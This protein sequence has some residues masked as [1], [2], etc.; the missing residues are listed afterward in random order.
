MLIPLLTTQAD[1]TGEYLT[2]LWVALGL[3]TVFC[4]LIWLGWRNRKRRQATL[5]APQEI[6]AH[7]LEREPLAAAEGMVIGTVSAADYL[8]RIAVH[9]LGL[10]TGGR[11]EHHT[12][13]VAVFRAGAR[14]YFIPAPSITS[15]RTDR[16]V[17]GKFVE[18]DGAIIIGWTLGETAVE[19][20][21]RARHAQTNTELLN[22]LNEAVTSEAVKK[23]STTE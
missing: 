10:R 16:G 7:L 9:Q 11:V 4:L 1:R 6:P 18:R 19:T 21:F 14:N 12:D 13:G 20:A 22:S 3:I 5:P 15:V 8:D 2:Y 23:E 17:V